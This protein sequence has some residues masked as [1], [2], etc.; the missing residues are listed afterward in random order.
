[1]EYNQQSIYFPSKHN[2]EFS[3]TDNKELQINQGG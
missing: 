3:L 2:G 1:M